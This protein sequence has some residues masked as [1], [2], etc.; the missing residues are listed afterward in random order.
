MAKRIIKDGIYNVIV[1][2]KCKCEFSFDPVTDVEENE[3]VI[4]PQCSTEN[5]PTKK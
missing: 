5:T 2:T 3:K 1:C 4:C